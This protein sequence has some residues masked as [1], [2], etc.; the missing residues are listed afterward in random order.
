MNADKILVLDYG[1]VV[2]IG[3]HKDL[4]K[5]N[6]FITIIKGGIRKCLKEDQWE[7]H[8]HQKKQKT[9]RLQ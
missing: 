8:A 2:G 9:L 3:K 5:T 4:L 7:D 1:R 6:C